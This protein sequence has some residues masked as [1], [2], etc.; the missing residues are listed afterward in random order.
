MV[1]NGQPEHPQDTPPQDAL[2]GLGPLPPE[3][4]HAPRVDRYRESEP[5]SA[6][7]L[8]ALAVG[9]SSAALLIALRVER[10]RSRW[11]I[12][13]IDPRDLT[14]DPYWA[15]S[16][17]RT[18]LGTIILAATAATMARNLHPTTS[19]QH[20]PRDASNALSTGRAA[21]WFTIDTRE[22]VLRA[23]LASARDRFTPTGYSLTGVM[24]GRARAYL[25]IPGEMRHPAPD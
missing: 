16:E 5:L 22:G 25:L 23:T 7:L 12:A 15:F 13:L 11:A 18:D 24:T 10:N 1:L 17:S 14:R 6:E 2:P 19:P 20:L 21:L 4:P 3:T 9:T 8:R